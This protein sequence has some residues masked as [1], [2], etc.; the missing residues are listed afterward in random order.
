MEKELNRALNVLQEGGLILYPTDTVWGIGCDATDAEAVRRVYNLKE[1]I[2][3][4]AL[5]CLASDVEMVLEY[6]TVPQAAREVLKA[7]KRPTTLIYNNPKGLATNLLAADDTIAIRIASDTFCQD[8]IRKFGKPIVSTS[9]NQAGATT[10]KRYSDIA[11][12][13]LKGVDYIVDLYRERQMD[14][15][16]R[17]LKIEED[18]SLRVIRD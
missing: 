6:A 3:S 1:R 8:L 16:S 12:G 5:I 13:I 17:I 15:P 9:A 11:P 7:A 4:K 14:I 18:G 2:D 10:P